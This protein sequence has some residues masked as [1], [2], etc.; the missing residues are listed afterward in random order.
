MPDVL[1]DTSAWIEATHP[2]GE[3][4]YREAIA[5]LLR[6]NRAAVTEPIVLEILAG[7]NPKK[8]QFWEERLQGT[9]SVAVQHED[10]YSAASYAYTLRRRGVTVKNFDILIA[11]VGME[12][13]LS[14]LHQDRD[15][16]LMTDH[17]PLEVFVP[18]Q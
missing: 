15:F 10:W 16:D 18:T 2:E 1:I 6:N 11:T 12:N 13:N 3:E 5:H 9:R 4:R 7:V 14:L 17:L 8:R